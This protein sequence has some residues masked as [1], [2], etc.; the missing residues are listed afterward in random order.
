MLPDEK[1]G[2][3]RTG[4]AISCCDGVTKHKCQ[5]WSHV[6]GTDAMGKDID[7]FG[8]ADQLSIK[9]LHEVAKEVRQSAA[10]CDKVATEVR[11]ASD[12]AA[13]R[14]VALINGVKAS[15]PLLKF[16]GPAQLTG[17]HND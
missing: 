17:D 9:F 4:F 6:S 15:L 1:I 5:L 12:A 11:K 8:C 3:H 10:S 14:D 7:V 13:M 16:N 2:C